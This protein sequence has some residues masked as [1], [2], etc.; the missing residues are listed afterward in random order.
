MM[1]TKNVGN[2]SE[3]SE[4]QIRLV[5]SSRGR[6]QAVRH[7]D[8]VGQVRQAF[9]RGPLAAVF[10]ALLGAGVPAG[11]YRMAH[12]ELRA[13]WWADPKAVIVAGG[14]LFSAVKVWG[15]ARMAF[16]S[17]YLATGFVLLAEGISVCS[18]Q[19]C[20]SLGALAYLVTINSISTS[21]TIAL[22]DKGRDR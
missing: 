16:R 11:V 9:S 2:R 10:G 6:R 17:P 15:W 21:C 7:L 3:V 20:L 18:D 13:E 5:R 1:N 8:V 12:F 19:A 4:P 14:L 22:A